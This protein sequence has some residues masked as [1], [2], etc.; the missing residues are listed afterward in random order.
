MVDFNAQEEFEK[1]MMENKDI[2]PDDDEEIHDKE[3]YVGYKKEDFD[4]IMAALPMAMNLND[5]VSTFKYSKMTTDE[6]FKIL[7]QPYEKL[8]I[9]S[10]ALFWPALKGELKNEQIYHQLVS[11]NGCFSKFLQ[12]QQKEDSEL[13]TRFEQIKKTSL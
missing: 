7:F 1:F 5:K 3:N 10:Q 13:L 12:L 4:R 2:F 6:R 8:H 9:L 11:S